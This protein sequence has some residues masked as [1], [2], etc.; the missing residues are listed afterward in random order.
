MD[1]NQL[2][3]RIPSLHQAATLFA[4]L[5]GPRDIDDQY[6]CFVLGWIAWN[7]RVKGKD[8]SINEA[9]FRYGENWRMIVTFIG[10]RITTKG[11]EAV[12]IFRNFPA[13][14]DLIEEWTMP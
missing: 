2:S 7:C 5:E 6:N 13:E 9:K 11:L 12:E 8:M 10:F 14:P 3:Q 4:L 1:V